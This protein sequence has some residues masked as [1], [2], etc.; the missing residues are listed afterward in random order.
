M[1]A[2]TEKLDTFDELSL[3]MKKRVEDHAK[4]I[5]CQLQDDIEN[6][7]Y[8]DWEENFKS[9]VENQARRLIINLLQGEEKLLHLIPLYSFD[10]IY[11]K[12]VAVHG[13]DILKEQE[14]RIKNLEEEVLMYR[15]RY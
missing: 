1:R 12:L 11:K 7:F 6:W 9:F 3:R 10:S 13:S 4:N 8:D 14:T 15:S 5:Y 2:R